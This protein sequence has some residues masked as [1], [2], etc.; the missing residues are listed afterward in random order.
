MRINAAA[1]ENGLT[2]AKLMNGLKLAGIGL[3]RKAL[4]DL[5]ARAR[6]LRARGGT[7]RQDRA[8]RP[9]G[10]RAARRPDTRG[11]VDVLKVHDRRRYPRAR[12]LSTSSWPR[13][14]SDADLQGA[15]HQYLGRKGGAIAALMKQVAAAPAAERPALGQLANDLKTYIEAAIAARDAANSWGRTD[16]PGPSTS[17][18]PAARL[19]SAAAIP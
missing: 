2:Y 17:R 19:A 4:A 14:A 12:A 16:R 3:D 8:G 9:L 5:A 15:E 11:V 18:S 1:R 7:G 6:C 13:R 10:P